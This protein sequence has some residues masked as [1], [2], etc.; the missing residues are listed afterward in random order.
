[1]PSI[2]D[3]VNTWS[4]A[5]TYSIY[6]IVNYNN[7]VYYSLTNGNFNQIPT[8]TL[9]TQWNGQILVGSTSV[10]NFF[11]KPSYSSQIMHSPRVLRLKFGNGYEQRIEDGINSNLISLDLTFEN[12]DENESTAILHFLQARNG[13]ESFVYNVPSIY[14]RTTF[15]TRYLCSSWNSIY[16]FYKN[17][18]I[19]MTLEEVAR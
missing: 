15:P 14:S 16:N 5:N 9:G 10:P 13:K 18:T 19:R 12:R 6:E 17:Y 8:S 1:M 4:N 3:T 7:L 11:W 2:F